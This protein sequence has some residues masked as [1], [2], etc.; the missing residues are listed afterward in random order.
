MRKL[1][2]VCHVRMVEMIA[3]R[4]RRQRKRERRRR[5]KRGR[6]REKKASVECW[7]LRVHT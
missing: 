2:A 1:F 5:R 3:R 7:E 4:E 6:G